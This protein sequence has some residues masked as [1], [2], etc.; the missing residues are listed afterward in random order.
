[1]ETLYLLIGILSLI[2]L[3][4]ILWNTIIFILELNDKIKGNKNE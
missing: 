4:S 1:M 2:F 3:P